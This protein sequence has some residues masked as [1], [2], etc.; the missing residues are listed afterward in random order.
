ME[1]TMPKKTLL[2]G[3]LILTLFATGFLL[4]YQTKSSDLPPGAFAANWVQLTENS[5]ILLTNQMMPL[6]T[7]DDLHGTLFVKVEKVWHKL[8]LDPGPASLINAQ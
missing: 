2:F 8:Y 3:T 7:R 1:G 5:G 4:S 6:R